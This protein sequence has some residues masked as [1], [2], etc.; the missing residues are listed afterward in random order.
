M[1]KVEGR[2]MGRASGKQPPLSHPML[3]PIKILGA[4]ACSEISGKFPRFTVAN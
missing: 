4:L 3:L 2:R 1:E